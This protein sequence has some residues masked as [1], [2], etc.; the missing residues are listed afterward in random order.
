MKRRKKPR[1]SAPREPDPVERSAFYPYLLHFLEWFASRGY[2]PR[3]LQI[4][5][6]GLRRFIRWAEERTIR[7]PQEVTR[8]VL[9]R[10]R[11]FLYHYRKDNGEPLSFATQMQRLIPLRVFFKW[12]AR[13]NHILGDPASE[14]ELPRVHRRLPAHILSREQVEQVMALTQRTD[15]QG[16]LDPKALRDRAILE[17]LY[18]SGIRRTE[19]IQ[20]GLYDVDLKNGTLAVRE[21]K[22]RKDRYVPLGSRAIH[23]IGRYLE[24]VRPELV[25][26]PD[27]GVL[28]LHEFGEPFS[29]NRL[30]DLVKKYLRAAGI[31]RGA[32]P[33]V[34][35]RHGDTDVG[36]RRR[37]P[38]HPGDPG[39]CAAHHDRDLH[40]RHDREVEGDP[41]AHA[42]GGALGS[43]RPATPA[44]TRCAR[45][46]QRFSRPRSAH[47][48]RRRRCVTSA[49]IRS[50]LPSQPE[51]NTSHGGRF[52]GAPRSEVVRVG[53]AFTSP[54][55]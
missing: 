47:R 13:E 33:P 55:R 20:L 46:A 11:R 35:A 27:P 1:A 39:P 9:E 28:F 37:Y 3:T 36:E 49:S 41:C 52:G 14:L 2:S 21:G 24:E 53:A 17:T 38:L 23:W 48:S 7:T 18:S 44:R 4:R 42:P 43:G 54:S 29:K 6:D 25:L 16:N 51:P 34:P 30:T 19:L 15:D 5:S 50:W 10:Y 8:P 22:G 12:L 26:E 31:E 45:P 40:A 32:C